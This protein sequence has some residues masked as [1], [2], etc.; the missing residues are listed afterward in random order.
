[1]MTFDNID[2]LYKIKLVHPK[3]QLVLRFRTD[4]SKSICKLGIKYGAQLSSVSELLLKSIELNLQV[5]GVSFHVGSGCFDATAFVDA[6]TAAHQVFNCASSFG[7]KLNLLDIGGG[8]PGGNMTN[9]LS[10]Q[11]VANAVN[12][13]LDKLFPNVNI[14]A[15]PGRYYVSSAYTLFLPIIARRV[16]HYEYEEGDDAKDEL[17]LRISPLKISVETANFEN[18][19]KGDVVN[20]SQIVRNSH[21]GFMYFTSEGMYGAFNCIYF[22]HAQVH[23]KPLTQYHKLIDDVFT[24]LGLSDDVVN[25]LNILPEH[26]FMEALAPVTGIQDQF[27]C[28]IWGP[29]CDSMDCI[30]KYCDLPELVIGDWLY[31]ENMGAYTHAAATEFNGFK[32]SRIIY[33]N[34]G[35]V[36]KYVE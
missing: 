26:P 5:I 22:D 31:F 2:E 1:V 4:D 21:P 20:A 17:Q 18:V 27:A 11:M 36:L 14:I 30:T 3:A 23:G 9:G 19:Q 15:E 28:S 29:T 6:L 13:L 25:K 33:V 35:Q 10:F 7:L 32:K 12:P 8:F 16:V 24:R 34:E